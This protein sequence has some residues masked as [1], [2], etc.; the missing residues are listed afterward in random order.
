M[1]TCVQGEPQGEHAGRPALMRPPSSPSQPCLASS[2][3]R[4][5][6]SGA[7]ESA[8]VCSSSSSGST[9]NGPMPPPRPESGAQGS[10]RLVCEACCHAGACCRLAPVPPTHYTQPLGQLICPQPTLR[11]SSAGQAERCRTPAA[12]AITR[13]TAARSRRLSLVSAAAMRRR[14]DAPHGS[15]AV[16][17]AARYRRSEGGAC[18]R[19]TGGF[20]P[21]LLGCTAGRGCTFNFARG[22]VA[23]VS[24]PTSAHLRDFAAHG[25]PLGRE[26]VAQQARRSKHVS[27]GLQQTGCKACA[28]LLRSQPRH[29][30]LVA[31]NAAPQAARTAVCAQQ[32]CSHLRGCLSWLQARRWRA[33]EHLLQQRRLHGRRCGQQVAQ[34]AAGDQ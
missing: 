8:A 34:Q 12:R 17:S 3:R 28:S 11:L 18:Q 33:P 7:G 22:K 25:R 32:Y 9:R 14:K 5:S 13:T 21:S 19:G 31:G 10:R 23:R 2:R 15:M 27:R 16:A 24:N 30:G 20:R 26:E 4:A 1:Q 6:C 29:A